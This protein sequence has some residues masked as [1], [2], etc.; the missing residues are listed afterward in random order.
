MKPTDKL[1]LP[2]GGGQMACFYAFQPIGRNGIT[3]LFKEG[4]SILGLPN[5][6]NFQPH[7]L[8]AVF[9]TRLANGKGVSDQE[10]M[11]AARHNSLAASAIYQERD[12]S[13]ECNKFE[14]LGIQKKVR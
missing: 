5:P 1:F 11:D 6:G 10:R 9:V 12:S 4:A 13:S 7:S 3:D 2:N 14:A 8:R